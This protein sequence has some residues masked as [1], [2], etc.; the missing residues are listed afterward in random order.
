MK[1]RNFNNNNRRNF[2][3]GNVRERVPSKPY[4][5]EEAK[6]YQAKA[7]VVLDVIKATGAFLLFLVGL[8]Y[9]YG[10]KTD[11]AINNKNNK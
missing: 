10:K 11:D 4:F 5:P 9:Y 8:C 2:T 6:K 7:G 1:D 3:G